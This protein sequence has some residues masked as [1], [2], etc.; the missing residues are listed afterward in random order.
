MTILNPEII[1]L[2]KKQKANET[3]VAKYLEKSKAESFLKIIF[4]ALA[5]DSR[6]HAL[7]YDAILEVTRGFRF[8]SEEDKEASLSEMEKHINAEKIMLDETLKLAS[9]VHDPQLKI[10][11]DHIAED[12]KRHHTLLS[13]VIEALRSV[14]LE[15]DQVYYDWIAGL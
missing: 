1:D 13:K 10:V 3:E 2:V 7:L 9:E 14:E 8:Y 6:K 11:I 15:T 5:L 4:Q 12:E